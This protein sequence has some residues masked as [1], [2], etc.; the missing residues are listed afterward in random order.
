MLDAY[1]VWEN[2]ECQGGRQGLVQWAPQHPQLLAS[3]VCP[4][5]PQSH[6]S[7]RN[8]ACHERGRIAVVGLCTLAPKRPTNG[9]NA[10]GWQGK[11]PQASHTPRGWPPWRRSPRA[12]P[13]Q[14]A[15][16]RRGRAWR[17]RRALHPAHT[18]RAQLAP[19]PRGRVLT[20]CV[21]VG[22][23]SL[24]PLFSVFVLAGRLSGLSAAPLKATSVPSWAP[25]PSSP[26]LGTD[27][28]SR[29]RYDT[30]R[31][32]HPS[33][34][35]A[36]GRLNG[37]PIAGRQ[38]GARS[39]LAVKLSSVEGIARGPHH[40][41]RRTPLTSA[42]GTFVCSCCPFLFRPLSWGASSAMRRWLVP[43][44]SRSTGEKHCG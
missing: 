11:P 23:C 39:S 38:W 10:A 43:L 20:C 30:R 2:G 15:R 44:A 16:R 40:R 41:A 24:S 7:A 18:P 35:S 14:Q 25:S 22:G 9:A 6:P 13:P 4:S 27:G 28:R 21:L 8:C 19:R 32:G 5:R 1:E 29:H 37:V 34:L 12:R 33:R 17:P 3:A 42:R 31:R 36:A 26:S